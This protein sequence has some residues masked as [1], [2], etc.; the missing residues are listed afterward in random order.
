[1]T[2]GERLTGLSAWSVAHH[3]FSMCSKPCRASHRLA[4][5]M[6]APRLAMASVVGLDGLTALI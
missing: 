2:S 6:G 5:V 1:M 3:I 4:S